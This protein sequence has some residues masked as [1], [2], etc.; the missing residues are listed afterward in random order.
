MIHQ[1]VRTMKKI[2]KIVLLLAITAQLTELCG[3]SSN[4]SIDSFIGFPAQAYYNQP[5]NFSIFLSNHDSTDYQ[6]TITIT[7]YNDS[8]DSTT[9][10][11]GGSYSVY[12]QANSYDTIS[13]DSFEFDSASFRLGGN[14]VVVW[15]VSNNGMQIMVTD[16]FKTFVEILGYLG[17]NDLLQNNS[18][19][20]IYPVPADRTIFLPQNIVENSVEYVRIIDLMGRSVFTINHYPSAI[21]T[22]ELENGVYFLEVK[23]KNK[24]SNVL[25]FI[26]SR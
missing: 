22:D 26:V 18:L 14:V 12:I 1:N 13:V 24:N 20:L 4:I 9:Y 19:G 3:Q 2:I 7:Y 15:P 23:A 17:I 11:F 16:T 8:I 10:S 5:F 21:S 6:G 25:K